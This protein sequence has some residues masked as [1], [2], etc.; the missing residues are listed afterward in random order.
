[1]Q[2][3]H[4][5]LGLRK[6]LTEEVTLE[7]GKSYEVDMEARE[8][9]IDPHGVA[10]FILAK[11]NERFPDIQVK[12]IYVCDKTQEIK[13]QFTLVSLQSLGFT[14]RPTTLE[15]LTL[16]TWFPSMLLLIGV[17]LV[18][19]GIFMLFGAVPWYVWGMIGVGTIL[20]LFG[21]Q[22]SAMFIPKKY[23]K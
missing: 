4:R 11:I 14:P 8:G 5:L 6:S 17:A 20:V 23:G 3:G 7:V 15:A 2:L 1:M 13:L 18:F 10:N 22:L 12:W 16:I 21:P 9:I 19:I